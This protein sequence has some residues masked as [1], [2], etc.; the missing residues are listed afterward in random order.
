MK[1]LLSFGPIFLAVGTALILFGLFVFDGASFGGFCNDAPTCGVQFEGVPW[2]GFGLG[3]SYIL[4]AFF[5]GVYNAGR[6]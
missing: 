2:A 1:H 5:Y 6:K 4:A 3:I